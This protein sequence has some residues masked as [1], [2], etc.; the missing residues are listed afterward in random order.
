MNMIDT[1]KMHEMFDI[2]ISPLEINHT[3]R[4]LLDIYSGGSFGIERVIFNVPATIVI[5]K[6]GSKTVVKCA[7]ED[8]DPEKGLAMAIAKKALGNKGSYYNV[9]KKWLPDISD[10]D[11]DG[12]KELNMDLNLNSIKKAFGDFTDNLNDFAKRFRKNKEE[13]EE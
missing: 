10:G 8:F 7:K 6:D 1:T 13:N 3:R 12:D 9:F 4:M 11:V 5:W 2:D